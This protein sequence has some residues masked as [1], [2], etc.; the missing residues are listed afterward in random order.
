[1]T[2]ENLRIV[3]R[4]RQLY[5]EFVFPRQF[6]RRGTKKLGGVITSGNG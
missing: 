4:V 6:T 1:M 5:G 2:F 3:A